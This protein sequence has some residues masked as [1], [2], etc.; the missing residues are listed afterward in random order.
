[1]DVLE[2]L[3]KKPIGNA[4]TRFS[5]GDTFDLTFDGFWLIA[6]KLISSKDEEPNVI[7]NEFSPIKDTIEK[8]DVSTSTI[9]C[10]APG[11]K[12]IDDAT[13]QV[14]FEN[15]IYFCSQPIQ[16]SLIGYSNDVP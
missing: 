4:Y 11:K 5:I 12:V 10:C 14:C 7:L 6:Q 2:F 15:K 8:E 13:L 16:I 9:I 1:M 3:Q